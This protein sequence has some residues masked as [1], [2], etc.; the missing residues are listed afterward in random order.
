MDQLSSVDPMSTMDIVIHL[1]EERSFT[2]S[3]F[4][5]CD[6]LELSRKQLVE[7]Q[8]L[9]HVLQEYALGLLKND[10]SQTG[11]SSC[12][13]GNSCELIAAGETKIF[14]K[15]TVEFL[16]T[17][18][19]TA[20]KITAAGPQLSSWIG[21]NKN[22]ITMLG[23][24]TATSIRTYIKK[25]IHNLQPIT[26]HYT[27]R[28]H[29]VDSILWLITNYVG[30][31]HALLVICSYPA[32][33]LKTTSS[34]NLISILIYSIRHK[35]SL[36][37]EPLE[38]EARLLLSESS[39]TLTGNSYISGMKDI[40]LLNDVATEE[41]DVNTPGSDRS[42]KR[43]RIEQPFGTPCSTA[44]PEDVPP[45]S[46]PALQLLNFLAAFGKYGVPQLLFERLGCP[47]WRWNEYGVP[48]RASFDVESTG[49]LSG[50]S[51]PKCFD[52]MIRELLSFSWI[53]LEDYEIGSGKSY[54]IT[55]QAHQMDPLL[56]TSGNCHP[57]SILA[58]KVVCHVFPRDPILDRSFWKD[59]RVLTPIV[60]Q[61]YNV[62]K[63]NKLPLSNSTKLEL[64]EVLIARARLGSSLLH[65]ELLDNAV[66]LLGD[67]IPCHLQVSIILRRSQIA[68]LQGDFSLSE[69]LVAFFQNWSQYIE[70]DSA[71][72]R[73][74]KRLIL[75]SHLENLIQ[76]GHSA[77]AM[78]EMVVLN[79]LWPIQTTESSPLELSIAV[80]RLSTVSK[81][82]QSIGH[83]E[84][85]T[86]LLMGYYPV[87]SQSEKNGIDP[88]RFQI[89]CRLADLLCVEGRSELARSK[90]ELEIKTISLCEHRRFSRARR[91]LEISLIDVKI[92]EAIHAQVTTDI[93]KHKYDQILGDIENLKNELQEFEAVSDLDIVDR[94]MRVRLLV[95]SARVLL[96]QER[97]TDAEKEWAEV[98]LRIGNYPG[99][100]GQQ[101]FFSGVCHLSIFFARA[102][103]SSRGLYMGT[104]GFTDDWTTVKKKELEEICSILAR[105]AVS[106][107]I[108]TL[109]KNF[110]PNL[111]SQIATEYPQLTEGND[112]FLITREKFSCHTSPRV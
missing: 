7:I 41:R 97:F 73:T 112:D 31:A 70:V 14:S 43:R 17:L 5:A 86:V 15:E 79:N 25:G 55:A 91:R 45:P 39:S 33:S 64:A 48:I 106:Y 9:L 101:G 67:Q 46:A 92:A 2:F 3:S 10:T 40:A 77:R 8:N 22:R 24:A 62:R 57:W 20:K 21:S 28:A 1:N 83:L 71:R 110:L 105:E 60:D 109:T 99:T 18:D 51:E 4:L 16:E 104:C 58:L 38:I 30:P 90:I 50:L 74:L 103:A 65:M 81:L 35:D 108:P 23:K 94:W 52:E 6:K 98:L 54:C 37:C 63:P 88:N 69:K 68:R 85:A 72:M 36:R 89:I 59:G 27:N 32:K 42:A 100:F 13:A 84:E 95:A 87:L 19:E 82:H 75:L 34:E 78:R 12:E 80:Q 61:L 44:P 102:Q 107:W 49:L 26:N 93:S 29:Q 53:R 76:L 11:E 56:L 66:K 111:L 96:L 47:Q